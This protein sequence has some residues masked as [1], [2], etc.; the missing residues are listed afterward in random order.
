MNVMKALRETLDPLCQFVVQ[1]P[2]SIWM[3][4][5]LIFIPMR[6]AWSG[7]DTFLE[8]YK[9]VLTFDQLKRILCQIIQ[10]L[11][12]LH[13][14]GFVYTD[15]KLSNIL[16]MPVNNLDDVQIRVADLGS[17]Y[18]EDQKYDSYVQTIGTTSPEVFSSAKATEKS[19]VFSLGML[20]LELFK[21]VLIYK[22][23]NMTF[24][25]YAYYL[26][27]PMTNFKE[28]VEEMKESRVPLSDKEMNDVNN[29]IGKLL[30]FNKNQRPTLGQIMCDP[31]LTPVN[32]C[33]NTSF[34]KRMSNIRSVNKKKR[35]TYK[36]KIMRK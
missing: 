21:T 31:F 5:D 14:L 16:V 20:A 6:L 22:F 17:A 10:A 4:D 30:K 34:G 3:D 8:Q 26:T 33:S 24:P 1:I 19:M 18:K 25:M 15:L 36:K 9:N 2:K 23:K 32:C 28:D 7:L 11:E 27:N 12:C 13:R 35:S 29:F